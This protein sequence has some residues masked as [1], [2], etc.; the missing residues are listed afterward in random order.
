LERWRGAVST[1]LRNSKEVRL[2][3]SPRLPSLETDD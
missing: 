3:E 1:H 2:T